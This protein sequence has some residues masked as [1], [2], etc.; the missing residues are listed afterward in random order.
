MVGN[1]ISKQNK[2]MKRLEIDKK[3]NKVRIDA[4]VIKQIDFLSQSSSNTP[5]SFVDDQDGPLMPSLALTTKAK[6][7]PLKLQMNQTSMVPRTQKQSPKMREQFS[8]TILQELVNSDEFLQADEYKIRQV[9]KQKARDNKTVL[10]ILNQNLESIPNSLSPAA[11]TNV[12]KFVKGFAK[13]ADKAQRYKS[14][15]RGHP[16]LPPQ[17]TFFPVVTSRQNAQ[18]WYYIKQSS[19]LPSIVPPPRMLD[20]KQAARSFDRT[21]GP[22][23]PRANLF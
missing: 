1:F 2:M 22:R 14:V 23:R 16:L 20:H 9:E 4:E 18:Q 21:P 5:L 17:K 10:Q 6:A 19:H 7:N 3:A 8:R 11:A 12:G 15:E 13:K